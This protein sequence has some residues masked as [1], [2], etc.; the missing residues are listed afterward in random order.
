MSRLAAVVVL[1]IAQ[2][3]GAV[4][5]QENAPKARLDDFAPPPGRSGIEIGQVVPAT[6]ATTVEQ[7]SDRL[8]EAPPQAKRAA[9][10]SDRPPGPKDRAPVVQ[11]AP[12]NDRSA[13]AASPLSDRRDSRPAAAERLAG[14]D[15]CD[16]RERE[17][18][19][20]KTCRSILE[21]RAREFSATE[22]PRLSAEQ[23]LL[24]R[25]FRLSTASLADSIERSSSGKAM[26]DADDRLA[27]ELGF[28]ALPRP[29]SEE[30]P[31]DKV[32]DEA[33]LNE[34]LKGV[35]LQMGVQP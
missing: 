23:E 16:P 24:A 25:Q 19:P 7:S 12:L 13:Q 17:R 30:T 18:Q 6:R 8:I 31:Q 27:Q 9:L 20:T 22:A 34:A 15:R 26:T 10:L 3:A 29:R 21:L 35:L 32:E 1:V 33:T 11:V 4:A 5:A 28:L 2:S 14:S